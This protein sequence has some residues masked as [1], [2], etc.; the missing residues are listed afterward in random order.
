[1]CCDSL[2]QADEKLGLKNQLLVLKWWVSQDPSNPE[3]IGIHVQCAVGKGRSAERKTTF[4]RPADFYVL[5][6]K[7]VKPR[8]WDNEALMI[9]PKTP[10]FEKV[11]G[12][13]LP[14]AHVL[15]NF[16]NLYSGRCSRWAQLRSFRL[17][18]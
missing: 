8:A 17:T 18:I 15:H 4:L 7:Q 5:P 3:E 16:I 11:S 14:K 13:R 2:E 1:M 9:S 6:K 10:P 12:I